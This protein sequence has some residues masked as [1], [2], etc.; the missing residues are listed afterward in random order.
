LLASLESD[1]YGAARRHAA[2]SRQLAELLDALRAASVPVLVLKGMALAEPVYGNPALRP[3]E[4]IDLL[5]RRHD[6]PRARTALEPLGYAAPYAE[7]DLDRRAATVLVP[8]ATPSARAVVDLHWALVDAKSG[9]TA[10]RW[11]DGVWERARAVTLG[12][13]AARTLSPGDAVIHACVHLAVNHGLQ[14]LLWYCDLA[15]MARAWQGDLDWA[16]LA[17]RV[18]D[19]RLTGAVYAA[20]AGA[21]STVGLD[22][23]VSVL[24]RLRPRSGRIALLERWLLP[25]IATLGSIPY[26]DYLVP[27]FLL[28]RGRDVMSLG[29]R[30][31]RGR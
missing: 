25:R 10:G 24:A 3:M 7:Q 9:P 21:R 16:D 11:A 29:L 8:S 26:Q 5:V 27:L 4:D 14:G 2:L 18:A 30:R 28:D 13:S 1:Y 12:G 6:V 20:L 17:A 31:L 22:V 15:M 19:A 23:P